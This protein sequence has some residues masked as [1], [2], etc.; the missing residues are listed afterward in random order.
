MRENANTQSSNLQIQFQSTRTQS[1]ISPKKRGHYCNKKKLN[2]QCH[3]HTTRSKVDAVVQRNKPQVTEVYH[4]YQIENTSERERERERG[5]DLVDAGGLE[6]GY[7]GS[8]SG[9]D[10]ERG[11]DEGFQGHEA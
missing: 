4:N 10:E 6:N 1:Q 5:A 11:D 8:G 9:A 3:K 7:G 2:Q